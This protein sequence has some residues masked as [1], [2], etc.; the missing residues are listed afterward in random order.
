MLPKTTIVTK[1]HTKLSRLRAIGHQIRYKTIYTLQKNNTTQFCRS[2][3][4]RLE[5]SLNKQVVDSEG[6]DSPRATSPLL[7]NCKEP[8]IEIRKS[9][10][11]GKLQAT[12][13]VK[14]HRLKRSEHLMPSE[15]DGY[16]KVVTNINGYS[17]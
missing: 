10:S 5:R 11:N 15:E 12:E 14:L 17:D 8:K 3:L 1:Q 4:R 9:K 7:Q 2:F 16:V 6:E 13:N